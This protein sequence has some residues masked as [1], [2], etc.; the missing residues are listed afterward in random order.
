MTI[1]SDNAREEAKEIVEKCIKCGLC[2]SLCPVFKVMREEIVSPRGKAIAINENLFEKFIY[3]C[4]L[5]GACEKQCPLNLEL[6]TAFIQSRKVLVGQKKEISEN[7]KMIENL[8]KT[9]N[10]FGIEKKKD[11]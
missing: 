10:I 5:C 11:L 3:S 7:K 1:E 6:C 2:K 4:T 9:G 8:N